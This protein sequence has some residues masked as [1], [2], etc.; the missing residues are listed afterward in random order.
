MID[1]EAGGG[2]DAPAAPPVPSFASLRSVQRRS[3]IDLLVPPAE[4]SALVDPVAPVE[5]GEP[6][7]SV[8]RVA[9]P[10]TGP[11]PAQWG[12]LLR[13]GAR[14]GACLTDRLRGLLRG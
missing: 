5:L 12:D 13:L 2:D 7:R 9:G 10:A 11:R 4:P 1:H 14:L 6:A 8:P 3:A